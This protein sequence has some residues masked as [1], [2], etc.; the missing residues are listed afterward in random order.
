M[1]PITYHAVFRNGD[2][3][4]RALFR[5]EEDADAWHDAP[6]LYTSARRRVVFDER[7]YRVA[8]L[9]SCHLKEAFEML[10]EICLGSDEAS[11]VALRNGIAFFKR[12][13]AQ[14]PARCASCGYGRRHGSVDTNCAACGAP[15]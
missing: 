3:L 8:D 10:K 7:P 4:P 2:P 14:G 1:N 12:L 15:L 9:E 5:L 6:E 11:G 13:S